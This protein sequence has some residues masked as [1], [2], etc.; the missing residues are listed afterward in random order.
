M[1]TNSTGS[2]IQ[3]G[4]VLAP[5]GRR[6]PFDLEIRLGSITADGCCLHLLGVMLDSVPWRTYSWSRPMLASLPGTGGK[7]GAVTPSACTTGFSSTSVT[8]LVMFFLRSRLSWTAVIRLGG[9]MC[10]DSEN[11]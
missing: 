10:V 6:L 5:C 3:L 7:S 9:V 1:A 11:I 2:G 4:W 8:C